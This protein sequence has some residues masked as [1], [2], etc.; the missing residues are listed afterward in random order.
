MQTAEAEVTV[1]DKLCRNHIEVTVILPPGTAAD[2]Q[3]HQL[4][5]VMP[6]HQQSTIGG[7]QE[8][9][10]LI[11]AHN[12]RSSSVPSGNKTTGKAWSNK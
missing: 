6:P 11:G 3:N 10:T 4:S 2:N 12:E 9:V 1:T 5:H 8:A 7:K